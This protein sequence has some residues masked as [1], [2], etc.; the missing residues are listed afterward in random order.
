MI[1][2]TDILKPYLNIVDSLRSQNLNPIIAGSVGLYMV[3]AGKPN[4]KDLDL[5]VTEPFILDKE[6]EAITHYNDGYIINGI[7]VDIFTDPEEKVYHTC[8]INDVNYYVA[9]PIKTLLAKC[10]FALNNNQKQ[11]KYLM[12]LLK[13]PDKI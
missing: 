12:K 10:K 13:E 6:I 1:N 3:G 8:R 4:F 11:R 5:V 2:N 7:V 9:D